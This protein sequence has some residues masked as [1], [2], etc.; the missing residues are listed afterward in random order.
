MRNLSSMLGRLV[1]G[2]IEFVLVGGYA[3]VAHGASLMTRD[4]DIC[5]SFSKANLF[6]LRDVLADLHPRHRL[7]R[8]RQPLELDEE[9]C[10]RLRNLYL[11]T[12]LC[13]LDC[14]SEVAGIGDYEKVLFHSQ[15]ITFP[16][17]RFRV[18]DLDGLILAKEA[19]DRPHDRLTLIQL[20]AIKERHKP[21]TS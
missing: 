13:T 2:R 4:V 17:G 19:M 7:T 3:A 6:R 21:P 14:L 15:E 12:D 10:G 9:L 8:E 1:S 20:R 11:D 5:C 16:E 18:L